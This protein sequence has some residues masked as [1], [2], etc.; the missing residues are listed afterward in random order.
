MLVVAF[1]WPVTL[2]GCERRSVYQPASGLRCKCVRFS[3]EQQILKPVA[4]PPQRRSSNVEQLANL[5]RE[6]QT[7]LA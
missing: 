7:N 5:S 4:L 3:G 2:L 6:T 1:R